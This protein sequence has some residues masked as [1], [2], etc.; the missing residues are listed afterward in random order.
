MLISKE[1]A[2]QFIVIFFSA[3]IYGLLAVPILPNLIKTLPTFYGC[4]ILLGLPWV[5]FY[6]VRGVG[7]ILI[8]GLGSIL[9]RT[10]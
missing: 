10:R 2:Y 6:G 9:F 1:L 3:Y 7:V 4:F 5:C 8:Q